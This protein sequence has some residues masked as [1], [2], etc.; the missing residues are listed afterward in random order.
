MTSPA[1]ERSVPA[2]KPVATVP[3]DTRTP[4]FTR[5]LRREHGFEPLRVEGRLPESLRGTLVR[6]GPGLYERFGRRYDHPFEGDGALSAVRL[7]GQKAT[8][9]HR[10]VAS[11]GL[12]EERAAGKALYGSAPPFPRRLWNG[13]RR[14]GKNTANTSVLPWQGRLFALMEGAQ[15]TEIDLQDLGTLGATDLGGVT[16]PTFSAHPHAVISRKA[17]YNFGIGY[18]RVTELRLMELP[19]TGRARQIGAIPL[20]HPLLVHDF[21]ATDRHLVFLLS[22][23][24]LSILRA[25]LGIG[26][27]DQM[28]QWTPGDGTEVVVVPI[29]R[30]QAFTRFR[31]DAFFQWHFANA[32][33][34]GDTIAVDLVRRDDFAS[35]EQIEEDNKSAEGGGKLTRMI[36]NPAARSLQT[37]ERWGQP[38]EFPRVDPRVEG[39]PH[40]YV[41]VTSDLAGSRSVACVDV[42]TGAARIAGVSALERPSEPVF[43]PRAPD[44]PEGDGWVLSLIYDG[45]TDTSHLAIFDTR[46]FEDGP[47]ARAH[48]D[49]HVPM[50]FHGSWIASGN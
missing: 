26:R 18:G 19:F 11:A 25:L 5:S 9:A 6:N 29:D 3:S 39:A 27:F 7:D 49:H 2:S 14:R 12:L 42:Q 33:E 31:V 20:P 8:G 41:W 17:L 32:F 35:F 4:G 24:R 16:G 45:A 15:P 28:L 10:L 43:V 37:E 21:I 23:V 48:F 47:V 40:R 30:P 46:S 22:P 34:Q 13:L 1:I 50:T 44:A 36:V 38:C